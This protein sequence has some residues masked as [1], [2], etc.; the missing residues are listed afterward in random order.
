MNTEYALYSPQ[1][2][3]WLR[4]ADKHGLSFRFHKRGRRGSAILQ[5]V[6]EYIT[7][8]GDPYIT[9]DGVL[10][11]VTETPQNL[12]GI[13]YFAIGIDSIG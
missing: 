5:A 4:D 13:G 12:K 11:Y 10:D 1:M 2:R 7:E 9:E 6:G 8:A 3:K